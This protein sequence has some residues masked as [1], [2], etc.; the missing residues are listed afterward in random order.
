MDS[1]TRN[2]TAIQFMIHDQEG[3]TFA[4]WN[5]MGE[6]TWKCKIY[7]KGGGGGG[8]CPDMEEWGSC[9]VGGINDGLGMVSHMWRQ[10][11]GSI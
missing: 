5:G 1:H 8:G 6:L 11:W 9:R 2:V 4:E 3:Y 7:G 10:K